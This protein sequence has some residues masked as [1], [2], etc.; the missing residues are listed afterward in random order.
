MQIAPGD[1]IV[2]VVASK[3]RHTR[4]TPQFPLA[5]PKAEPEKIIRKINTPQEGTSTIVPG[6][7]G[8]FHNPS[9]KT[10]VVSSHSYIIPSVGVSK[11]LNFESLPTVFSPPSLGLEGERFDTPISPEFVPWFKPNT[12]KDFPTLGFT[13]PPPIRVATFTEEETSVPLSLV[14]SSP[15]P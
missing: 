9:L 2:L 11:N 7:F 14:V 3:G 6:I 5:T 15:N 10:P 1:S 8:N 13:T 12:S 4:S